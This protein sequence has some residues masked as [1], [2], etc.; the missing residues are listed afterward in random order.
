MAVNEFQAI[1]GVLEKLVKPVVTVCTS[2][3]TSYHK[4]YP[5]TVVDF[6]CQKRPLLRRH[7][8]RYLKI[9]L[10]N[11]TYLEIAAVVAI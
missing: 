10:H 11:L 3:L 4:L 5:F 6:R 7:I 1:Y 9:N 8:S 2:L